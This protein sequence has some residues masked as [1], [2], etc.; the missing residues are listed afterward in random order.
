MVLERISPS[1]WSGHW[2]E[3]D[4]RS[5]ENLASATPDPVPSP[6]SPRCAE[7]MP[8][9]TTD[10][11]PSPAATDEPSPHG[12]TEPRI[13]AEP[14]LLIMSVK[15]R[16]PATTPVSR[17]RAADGVSAERSSCARS[18]KEYSRARALQCPL[19]ESVLQSPRLQSYLQCRLP[20]LSSALEARRLTN[21]CPPTRSCLLHRCRL[22]APLL[23]LS[24]PS[25][26]C[27]LRGTAILQRCH[28]R[29][30]P[31]LCLQPPRR[32]LPLGPLTRRLHHGS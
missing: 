13:A 12:A 18:P 25:I 30:F 31:R 20:F 17:E 11:E 6:P 26:R 32:G 27:K 28:G 19:P 10:G 9:P 15:V 23:V 5:Q 1:L 22:A 14:E 4:L 8:E 7:R 21:A 3:T 24:P 29:S 2:R 16:E